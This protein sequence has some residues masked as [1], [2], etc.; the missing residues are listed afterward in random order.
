VS[1]VNTFIDTIGKDVSGTVVPQI[2]RLAQEISTRTFTQYGPRVSA[3][4]S[5]LAKDIIDEQ[6]ATVR[7]FVTGLI[8][9]VFQR[10]R[11]ELAGELH[12]RI[13]QGGLEVTGRGVRLDMKRRDTGEAVS[14]LDIPVSLTIKVDALGVTLQNATVDLDVI[15]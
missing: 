11:P 8:Q 1:D 2:E 7:D 4:A 14:S 3:F 15:R 13:V 5:Q 6:S 12:T 10:Y 9:E